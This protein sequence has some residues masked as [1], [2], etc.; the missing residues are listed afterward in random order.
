MPMRLDPEAQEVWRETI[1]HLVAMRVLTEAEERDLERYCE[2]WVKWRRVCSYLTEHGATYEC[3]C[4]EGGVKVYIRP[5]HKLF[6][7]YSN[8][9]T[10]LSDRFGLNPAARAKLQ[11]IGGGKAKDKSEDR[12]RELLPRRAG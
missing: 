5:E 1:P 2:T 3:E 11:T 6:V 7:E 8:I 4:R 10:A 9:L 12:L